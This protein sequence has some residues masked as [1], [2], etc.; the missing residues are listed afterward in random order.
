MKFRIICRVLENLMPV[1]EKLDITS[2][3]IIQNNLT[4]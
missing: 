3:V 2:E 1:G 4:H